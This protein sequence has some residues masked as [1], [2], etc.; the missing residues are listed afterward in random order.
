MGPTA[1][2]SS[3]FSRGAK[4]QYFNVDSF[5]KTFIQFGVNKTQLWT[6]H[7]LQILR[8]NQDVLRNRVQRKSKARWRDQLPGSFLGLAWELVRNAGSQAPPVSLNQNVHFNLI[9]KF[10]LKKKFWPCCIARGHPS[11]LTRDRNHAPCTGSAKFSPLNCQRSPRI[12]TLKDL[13]VVH[14]HAWI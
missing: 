6:G 10:I 4:I 8:W 5:F 3:D 14:L 11:S 7:N 12:C 1:A 2:G 13:Q 9:Y